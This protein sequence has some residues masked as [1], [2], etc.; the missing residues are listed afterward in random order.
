[1]R[2]IQ[3]IKL[4][5]A[6]GAFTFIGGAAWL[7]QSC[8]EQNKN[9]MRGKS[10]K[11]I[12]GDFSTE[13]P[14]PPLFDL[15]STTSFEAK[16]TPVEILK[17]KKTNVYGYYDDMLGKTF[18]VNKGDNINLQFTNS[19]PQATNIHW[20]GL[21][22]PPGMDG[23]PSLVT[24]PG[25]TFQYQ[26]KINQRA[27]TYWY[28]PH[29]D[30]LT[31]EQVMQG[32]A[33]FFIV[34][35]EEEAALKLPDGDS[36]IAF[37]IQDRRFKN[38]GDFDYSPTMM[39]V[40]TGFLGE[41][42][43]VNGAY[44]PYKA[45]KAG[46]NR[47][48]IINGSNA[49]VYN[50]A[51]SNQQNF[52]VIG[53]DAGLLTTPEMIKNI[54]LSP[55][56]RIDMLVDFTNEA[57]KE[58]FLQSELFNGGGVQGK[59][60]F[61]IIKFKAGDKTNE[62]FSLP[63]VLSAIVKINPS[64]ATKTRIFDISNA[65]MQGEK[66]TDMKMDKKDTAAENGMNNMKMGMHTINGISYNAAVMDETVTAGAT[67]VWEFDNGKGDEI[68]PM[69]FH[70]NHFQVLERI[71]GRGKLT[72]TEKGWK[73]TVLLMPGEKVKVITTFSQFKGKYVLH[74]H[75]LEHEDSGMML[76]FEIV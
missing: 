11:I 28:H 1:M 47:L 12:E 5:G 16:Q 14:S 2:R 24:Q 36:E 74:C 7:L 49:R 44:N 20:H 17:G 64:T 35:D 21:I 65:S 54:L 52:F 45:V 40:M 55:G 43:I 3:F 22:I 63:T 4:T 58:I 71:G 57:N 39:E 29:P 53:S 51:F 38:T 75:N 6:T 27:G 33:G 72:A 59:E 62:T 15:K 70:G 10:I 31:A 66:M 37:V 50:L 23:F 42:I 46:W 34:R 30:G 69:H 8:N 32:L 26:F 73:D 19:L 13:L 56:E 60:A 76:N 41:Y 68:H 18:I 61:K 67:E 9:R 48:R 25:G